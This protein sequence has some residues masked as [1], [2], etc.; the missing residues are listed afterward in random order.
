MQDINNQQGQQFES[1]RDLLGAM[2]NE[3]SVGSLLKV[4]TEHLVSA[5][6]VLAA[7]IWLIRSGDTC[8]SC[9][10]SAVCPNKAICSHLLAYAGQLVSGQ[11]GDDTDPLQTR[12][13]MGVGYVGQ[14]ASSGGVMLADDLL[15]NPDLPLVAPGCLDRQD[16]GGFVSVPMLYRGN[17]LGVLA[18]FTR[19]GPPEAHGLLRQRVI[20]DITAGVLANT[21][22]FEEIERLRHKLELENEYL[23]QEISAEGAFYE[24]VGSSP[25]LQGMQRQIQLVAPTDASV[26]VLGES[27]TGKELVAREIHKLS[28]RSRGPLIKVNCAAI[29]KELYESEFFGH[30]KGSFTGAVADR[31][32]RFE[33]ADGGTLFLDEVGEIPLD[34]QTKLLRVLQ[35]GQYERIG[36]EVT[37]EVD[38]R[39]VAATNR[40]LK[41]DVDAR[42]FR[43]DLYYRLNVFPIEVAPLRERKEDIAILAE[44]FLKVTCRKMNRPVLE[45]T[46]EATG[47]MQR[48]DWPGNIRELQ[49]VIER[50]VITANNGLLRIELPSQAAN[51]LTPTSSGQGGTEPENDLQVITD[52]EFRQLERRNIIA[53]LRITKWKMGGTNGAASLLGIKP[54]TLASRMKAM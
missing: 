28:N 7:G 29:P 11:A 53:A 41:D 36:D 35:E 46:S 44:H 45:L 2:M 32:G 22:A 16:A 10:S 38:V 12:I 18:M 49:N 47:R 8:S 50:A 52:D 48:Y 51:A 1:L 30:V 19:G 54:T 3:R 5:G 25:A 6:D 17:V 42:R 37:R 39:I 4:T 13:P 23:R 33:A 21:R 24:M 14:V 27:G 40:N 26:L 43:E 20:A 9:V 15:D 31:A 34:M